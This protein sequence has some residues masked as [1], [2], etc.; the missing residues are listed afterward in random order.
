MKALIVDDLDELEGSLWNRLTLDRA[1]ARYELVRALDAD[2]GSGSSHL[3]CVLVEGGEYRSAARLSLPSASGRQRIS[4]AVYGRAARAMDL[5]GLRIQDVVVCSWP[6]RRGGDILVDPR[7]SPAE[8]LQLITRMCEMIEAAAPRQIIAFPDVLPDD[9]PLGDVL[10]QRGYL[11][12]SGLPIAFL[13]VRWDDLDGYVAMLKSKKRRKSVRLEM[14]R[15]QRSGA[16]VE[17][18]HGDMVDWNH[19]C[20]L[21]NRHH[22]RLNQWPAG[23]RS[24]TLRR[25]GADMGEDLIVYAS[26]QDGEILGVNIVAKHGGDVSGLW[27]G[28]DH[29]RAGPN[30]TYFNLAFYAPAEDYPR[31]GVRRVGMGNAAYQAKVSRGCHVV[32]TSFYV[33]F[34]RALGRCLHRPAMALQRA[35]YARKFRRFTE[36]YGHPVPGAGGAQPDS[37]EAYPGVTRAGIA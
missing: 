11:R 26:Q 4:S 20:E 36:L 28:V 37:M 12:A 17:R 22:E 18:Q 8:R 32:P 15:Y 27:V 1:E 5:I 21:L 29:E 9:A 14:R 25:L 6:I 16:A 7:S 31:L 34:P 30:F 19:T 10:G 35:W 23:H 2:P 24:S 13:D 33:R 3:Y